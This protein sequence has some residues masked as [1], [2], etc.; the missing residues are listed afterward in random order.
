MRASRCSIAALAQGASAGRE[1]RHADLTAVL[2]EERH[3][4]S[5]GS[6]ARAAL[7]RVVMPSPFLH[8]CFLLSV[9]LRPRASEAYFALGGR[10]GFVR[11]LSASGNVSTVERRV[12]L[13]GRGDHRA[14]P[15]LACRQKVSLLRPAAGTSLLLN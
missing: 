11:D 12:A 14:L 7:S 9:T 8:L 15:G 5:P 6:T 10:S 1:P 3:A 4:A 13:G 2:V